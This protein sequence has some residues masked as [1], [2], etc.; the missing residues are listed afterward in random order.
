MQCVLCGFG[1]KMYFQ[2]KTFIPLPILLK[3]GLP[4]GIFSD[5]K[6][7]FWYTFEGLGM[8]YLG[9]FHDRRGLLV[10]LT[11]YWYILCSAWYIFSHFGL[12]YQEKSGNPG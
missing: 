8:E 2:N 6:L 1:P 5:Q 3:A 12:M 11:A 4:D 9:I 10:Y 7:Q